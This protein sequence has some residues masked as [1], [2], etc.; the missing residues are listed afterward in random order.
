VPAAEKELSGA[1]AKMTGEASRRQRP[2]EQ[3]SSGVRFSIVI[4]SYNQRGFIKDGVESVLS[5][6]QSSKEVIVVDDG[7]QDGSLEVLKRYENSIRL[8]ALPAN[9]GPMEARNRGAAAAR[10]EYLIFLDG[11][12]LFPPWA[13][14]VY[15]QLITERRP[16]TIVSGPRW[17]EGAVPELR[18]DDAPKSVE[19]V[20]YES[21][22]AMDRQHAWLPG[23]FVVSRRAFRDVGGWSPEMFEAD[24]ADLASKLQFSGKSI[25][26]CSPYTMLYRMHGANASSFV[27]PFLR[28]AHQMINRE[29]AG[30]Y[31]GRRRKR[32]ERYALQAGC[33]SVV[34]RNALHA[35]LHRAALQLAVRGWSMILAAIVRKS[36]IALRGRR[37]VEVRQ[38]ETY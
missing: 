20:E 9:C 23:A 34:I 15:E 37:R 22:L 5:Q 14:D 17:F 25:L 36:I 21:L 30:L 13:L 11:D 31:P 3:D 10:G 28:G 19:F 4:T 38:L 32:F 24:L 27:P 35:G 6:R 26:V 7:S 2:A 8:L 18:Q 33:F 16:T 29:H 1:R 12:D